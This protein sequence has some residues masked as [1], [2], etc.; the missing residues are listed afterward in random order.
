MKVMS[1]GEGSEEGAHTTSLPDRIWSHRSE[2]E[3]R[4][5]GEGGGVYAALLSGILK[6]YG[7]AEAGPKSGV[8]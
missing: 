3:E 4:G 2:S 5:H 1:R 6:L 8:V 7:R